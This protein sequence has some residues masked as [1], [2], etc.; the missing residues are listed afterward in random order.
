MWL[1]HSVEII[2]KETLDKKV[3]ASAALWRECCCIVIKALDKFLRRH[4][5]SQKHAMLRMLIVS[6][7]VHMCDTKEPA[8]TWKPPTSLTVVKN[9]Q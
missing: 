1:R 6:V 9:G 2:S 7:T 5:Q 3:A 4:P 8:K